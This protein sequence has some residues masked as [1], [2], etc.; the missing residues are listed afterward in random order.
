[1]PELPEVEI[2]KKTLQKYVKNQYILDVKINNYNLR[3]RIDKNFCNNL[4]GRKINKITRRSK[5]LI[6]HLSD[7]NYFIIHL[8]MSGRIFISQK[9]NQR[10]R[11]DTSFYSTSTPITKHNHVCFF[12]KKNIVIYN[13]VRRFGF[14]KYFKN[15]E[16]EK[17][18]HLKN[19]GIEPLSKDLTISYIKK[20]IYRFDKSIK[21]ILMDQAFI[22]GLGNIYVNEIL[23]LSKVHPL[24]RSKSL[25][26][27]EIKSLFYYIKFVLKKSIRLGGSTIRDFHNSEG[28]SGKFQDTFK[29]YAQQGKRCIKKNCKGV[30]KKIVIGGRASFFCASCQKE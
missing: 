29:V 6:F 26:N 16:L 27:L 14:I 15:T 4:K 22:C 21:N 20:N 5:Y 18:A 25:N 13:D 28:K 9:K 11:L 24:R 3:Y 23:Y 30:I 19:L 2:T 12:F 17:S 8:G 7:K 10:L 1:M